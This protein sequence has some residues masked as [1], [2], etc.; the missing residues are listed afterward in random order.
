LGKQLHTDSQAGE[1][2]YLYNAFN[3][4]DEARFVTEKIQAWSGT[5]QEIAILYRTTAQ[6]RLFEE[7]LLTRQIPYRIYG[8]LR[9]YERLEIKDV[10][11]YLRLMQRREDDSAFERIINMPKRGIG[12]R[13]LEILRQLAR[14]KGFSLWQAAQEAIQ[15]QQ[16]K[17]RAAHAVSLFLQL[18]TTL[19]QRQQTLSL[20]E[21]ITHIIETIDLK[22]YYRKEGKE[23]AERRAENLEELVIAAREFVKSNRV[24]TDVVTA[25]LSH[26]AL[27]AG[28][29]QATTTDC[30]Q[31]MTL[32]A[33]KGLEFTVVFLCGLEENLFPHQSA[34]EDAKL[35]E[36]RRLCYV[37][38]T[39]SR[40]W[41]YLCYSESRYRYGSRDF[42]TPSRF[43]QEIPAELIEMIRLQSAPTPLTTIRKIIPSSDDF[44]I[45]Q[46]VKHPKFGI[47]LV[48]DQE[49]YNEYARIQV[50]FPS[51]SQWLI[52]A[53]A[54]LEKI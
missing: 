19:T 10:L 50:R 21:Q 31:L 2:I 46:R 13:T 14:Q 34:L 6:S 48:V 12:E 24:E 30:V 15:T 53:Y 18:I 35:E 41:L 11:A 25:F 20:P 17:A 1:P 33:A 22:A 5:Y 7:A 49:G 23:E 40:Q 36:E 27:E 32:H 4:T 42:T 37:G 16:I 54:R 51:G 45:G 28:E 47:G 39:R 8:G 44:Q 43:V 52:V 3:E 26:T 29:G 38:L 9:F